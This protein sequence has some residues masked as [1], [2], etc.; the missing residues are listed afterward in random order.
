MLNITNLILT[1]SEV[2]LLKMG[3]S[4]CPTPKPD[5]QEL[6]EDLFEFTRQLRLA[7]HFRDIKHNKDTSIVKLPSGFNPAPNANQELEKIIRG[8]EHMSISVSKRGVRPNTSRFGNALSSL[9]RRIENQEI[10]I[11]S[12]DKGDLTTIMTPSYYQ[13]MCMRELNKQDCYE[14]IGVTNPDESVRKVVV[15]FATKYKDVLTRNEFNFLTQRK[16]KTAYFYMLPKL[17]KSE[18]INNILRGSDTEYVHVKDFGE[19]I[20]GRPIVGGPAYHTSG[21]SEMVDILL[22]PVIDYI[23]HLLKDS[24]DFLDRLNRYVSEETLLFTC[25]IKSLYTNIT[26]NLAYNAIDFW[27]TATWDFID[28]NNRF[29]KPFIM[30]AL[31]IILT[32]NFFYFNGDFW[33]QLCGFAMGTKCAVKCANIVVAFL[34]EKMFVMLPTIYS[35]D[36]AEFFIQNYFRLLDDLFMEWLRGFDVERLYKL[37]DELDPNL[38][39][40]FSELSKGSDYLDVSL[41]IK[42][43]IIESSVYHKPT[44]SFN[45][46]HF[47]S[48]HPSHTKNHIALSLAKRIIRITTDEV[49][50]NA[51]LDDLKEHLMSRGHPS[52]SIDYAYQRVFSPKLERTSKKLLVFKSTYNPHHI[53][54]NNTITS[55]LNSVSPTL[56]KVFRDYR[57]MCSY[58]QPPSLGRMLISSKFNRQLTRREIVEIIGLSK[59]SK[60]I[61]CRDGLIHPCTEFTFGQNGQFQWT[62]N[63]NFSCNSRNVIYLVQCLRCWMFYIGQTKDMK[64]RTRKHKSDV[65]KPHNS[66]CRKLSEHLNKCSGLVMPFF[67]IYPIFYVDNESKRR[68][69]EKRFIKRFKPPLN[70]D[71]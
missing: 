50:K 53:Y 40:I 49:A 63:R 69:I 45:Y 61:Y 22:S 42:N 18:H 68:F 10:I 38:K 51:S 64:K 58:R 3:M 34:E 56:Q 43:K 44:D 19:Q 31:K 33:K 8:I 62:Y 55:C 36:L 30:E 16:Y 66:K 20:D 71:E 39:F 12:A 17:H 15:D 24:F 6:T 54:R 46:L 14:N 65:I 70:G 4:F 37:F 23:R 52:S 11:K 48:C 47:E 27:I 2:E 13:D 7:Y 35:K 9:R 41:R 5:P 21:L 67:R 28:P 29:Q 1:D 57:V 25:D 60:C 32:Y 26:H 59:C